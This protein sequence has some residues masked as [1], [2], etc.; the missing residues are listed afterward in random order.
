MPSAAIVAAVARPCQSAAPVPR[1]WQ[2]PRPQSRFSPRPAPRQ[3]SPAPADFLRTPSGGNPQPTSLGVEGGEFFILRHGRW[4]M[5]PARVGV[6]RQGILTGVSGNQFRP[7]GRVVP[8]P[9]GGP[10]KIAQLSP[11]S[12]AAGTSLGVPG[13]RPGQVG[14]ARESGYP[15]PVEGR[16]AAHRAASGTFA[17]AEAKVGRRAW[18]RA[19]STPAR[20]SLGQVVRVE[21]APASGR[22]RAGGEPFSP[23]RT[24]PRPARTQSGPASTP[25]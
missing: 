5:E 11:F 12:G 1:P 18:P 6:S 8:T 14:F 9:R 20:A 21:D 15:D 22:R 24:R 2:R 10:R 25:M 19:A 23:R 7:T 16:G 3:P 4:P 17:S 13:R